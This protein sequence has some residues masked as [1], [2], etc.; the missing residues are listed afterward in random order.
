MD[1]FESANATRKAVAHYRKA[2]QLLRVL[3]VIYLMFFYG[4]ALAVWD[5]TIWGNVL[6]GA[7][8]G[9]IIALLIAFTICSYPIF[10]AFED[11]TT[12][13]RD[14]EAFIVTHHDH[15]IFKR[16][17]AA[18]LKETEISRELEDR[19]RFVGLWIIPAVILGT[20]GLLVLLARSIL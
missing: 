5:F 3:P 14:L 10:A 16:G 6:W 9:A 2:Q 4:T 18:I 11:Q 17:S 15:A 12:S 7:V 13:D 8:A 19:Q 20:V 1:L